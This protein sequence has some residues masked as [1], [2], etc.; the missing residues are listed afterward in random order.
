M[1]NKYPEYKIK[2]NSEKYSNIHSNEHYT[3]KDN[4]KIFESWVS[5]ID[6]QNSRKMKWQKNSQKTISIEFLHKLL[7]NLLRIKKEIIYIL[8]AK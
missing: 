4:L 2:Y 7:Q 8:K 1:L 5:L 3:I 6:V